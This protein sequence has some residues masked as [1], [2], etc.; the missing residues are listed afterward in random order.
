MRDPLLTEVKRLAAATWEAAWPHIRR[1][2]EWWLRP[3]APRRPGLQQ[4]WQWLKLRP[5]VTLPVGALILI[6]LWHWYSFQQTDHN[7]VTHH[8]HADVLNPIAAAIGGALLA[9][10][11]IRQA[12]TATRQADI[13]SQRHAEQTN[14]DRQRRLT[15]SYSKAVEQLASEKIEVRLGGIYTLEQISRESSNRYWPVMETLTA[16]VRERAR[17]REPDESTRKGG[18]V[19]TDIGAVM[20]VI[21]RRREKDREREK[22]RFDDLRGANLSGFHLERAWLAGAHLEGAGLVNTHLEGAILND[23]HFGGAVVTGTHFE[24]ALL[25]NA[26]F[27]RAF[28]GAT[29]RF[30]DGVGHVAGVCLGTPSV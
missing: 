5:Q 29:A 24:G 1:T 11:A 10:A 17:W 27:E 12:R 20:T 9:W 2:W 26:H 8:P 3:R 16:F 22:G 6:V 19:P 7:G 25:A 14:A 18:E 21:G 23:V 15:E 4:T 28:I 13:A 30:I